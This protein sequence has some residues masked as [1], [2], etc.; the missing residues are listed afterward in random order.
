MNFSVN[1]LANVYWLPSV[2]MRWLPRCVNSGLALRKLLIWGMLQSPG[3]GDQDPQEGWRPTGTRVESKQQ[4]C[5]LKWAGGSLMGSRSPWKPRKEEAGWFFILFTETR[6]THYREKAPS[7]VARPHTGRLG[8]ISRS[9]ITRGSGKPASHG[10]S[11][12]R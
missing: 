11:C 1:Q 9:V 3:R 12:L 8:K 2:C 6:T 4:V 7:D 5:A 10:R